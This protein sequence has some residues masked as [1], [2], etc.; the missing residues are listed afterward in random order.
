[1]GADRRTN[2]A[3]GWVNGTRCAAALIR[4]LTLA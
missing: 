1:M 2:A 3:R 4:V